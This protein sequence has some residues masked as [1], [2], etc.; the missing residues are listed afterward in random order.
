MMSAHRK[1]TD[2]YAAARFVT[3]Y[4]KRPLHRVS[5]TKPPK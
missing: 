1:C 3:E 2:M 5:I 4:R